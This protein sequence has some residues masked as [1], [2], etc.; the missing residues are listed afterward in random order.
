MGKASIAPSAQIRWQRGGDWGDGGMGG[1]QEGFTQPSGHLHP[2]W[3]PELSHRMGRLDSWRDGTE[4]GD[5]G[6]VSTFLIYLRAAKIS[7]LAELLQ[8]HNNF[9]RQHSVAW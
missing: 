9:A 1:Q 5:G 6:G 3:E 8:N 7:R 4:V 2:L